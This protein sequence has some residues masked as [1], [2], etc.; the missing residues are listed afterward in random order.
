MQE[1]T[2]IVSHPMAILSVFFVILVSVFTLSKHTRFA[3]FFKF[4]P[5]VL[6]A[7]FIPTA[8]STFGIIPTQSEL[9]KWIKLFL[10]PVALFLFTLALDL[11]A[12]YKLGYKA[13]VMML[14]GTAGVV[15]GGPI[16]LLLFKRFLPIDSWMGMSAL[17]GSWIGGGANFV[18]IGQAVGASDSILGPF[19]VVDTFIGNIWLGMLIYLSTKQT[20]IDQWLKADTST[21]HDVQTKLESFQNQTSRVSSFNDFLVFIGLAFV[22][23]YLSFYLATLLPPLGTFIDQSTWRVI[24]ITT[25]G[26]LLSLTKFRNY[27]GAGVSKIGSLALYLL[28]TTIGAQADLRGLFQYPVFIL[29]GI[30]WILIHG[31][32]LFVT[33]KIIKAPIFFLAVG[34]QANIGAAAS[35]PVVAASFHPSLA[36]VGTLLAILGYVLGTYLGLVCAYVMKIIAYW[37]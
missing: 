35:A 15:I 7:Y 29:V 28:I 30:T 22:F 13:L 6:F 23:S 21:I 10:L 25:F 20:R 2:T 37:A 31:L 12:I 18:A 19:I 33:A 4:L 3:P 14:A 36:P 34:S 1:A 9:Y 32:I 5:P 24:L 17:A 8:L 16:S 11:K 27:E 26:V